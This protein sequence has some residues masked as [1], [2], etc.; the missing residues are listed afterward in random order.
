[1][2][3][4]HQINYS[5]ERHF[6]ALMLGLFIAFGII[7]LFNR[8]YNRLAMTSFCFAFGKYILA[9]LKTHDN[10]KINNSPVASNNSVCA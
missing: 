8:G 2:E 5:F 7:D 1:M 6:R 9:H 3:L 10:K 4:I